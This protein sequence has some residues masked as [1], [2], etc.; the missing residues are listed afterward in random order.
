MDLQEIAKISKALSDPT[1]LHIFE[2]IAAQEETSCGKLCGGRH[3]S[4]A[5]ISHHLK[6][7]AEAGLIESRREGQF[8]YSHAVPDTIRD[9]TRSLSQLSPQKRPP[10]RKG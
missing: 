1:R 6:I 8:V 5:T 2:V 4:P 10:R 3:L 9:Y 7:L